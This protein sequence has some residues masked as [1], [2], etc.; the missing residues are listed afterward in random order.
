MI[1]EMG[2]SLVDSDEEFHESE[3]TSTTPKV[4]EKKRKFS[5][6]SKCI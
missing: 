6:N 3:T 4:S 5:T 2:I 1:S